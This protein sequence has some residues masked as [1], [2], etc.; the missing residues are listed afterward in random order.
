MTITDCNNHIKSASNFFGGGCAANILS[1][2]YNPLGECT[3]SAT[4]MNSQILVKLEFDLIFQKLSYVW[5][6]ES[7]ICMPEFDCLRTS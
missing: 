1:D 5:H 6:Y 7:K 3:T 2:K 4:L